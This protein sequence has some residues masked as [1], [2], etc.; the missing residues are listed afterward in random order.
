VSN[1]GVY[2]SL[3]GS[4]TTINFSYQLEAS[5][6]EEVFIEIEVLPVLEQAIVD[7]ILPEVFSDDCGSERRKLRVDRRLAVAGVSKN[8]PDMILEDGK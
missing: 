2:G 5:T 3:E 8:P 1:A 7:S 6:E 4:S